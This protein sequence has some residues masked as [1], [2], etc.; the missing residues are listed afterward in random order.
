MQILSF[1]AIV[2]ENLNPDDSSNV[3]NSFSV[4]SRPPVV[5]SISRSKSLAMEGSFPGG[6]TISITKS[7]DSLFMARWQ[8]VRITRHFSSDQSW[9][10]WDIRY[11][12]LPA[13]IS[14][15]KS[16]S[17]AWQRSSIPR[18]WIIFFVSWIT[19]GVSAT[20]PL[21]KGFANRISAIKVPSPPPIS[22]NVLMPEKS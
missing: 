1:V 13:G 21:I 9:R 5:T 4:R 15:K 10:T 18:V 2:L 6:I 17:N 3:L 16:H 22:V 11:A 7:L 8:F 20:I 14:L 19:R 12:S